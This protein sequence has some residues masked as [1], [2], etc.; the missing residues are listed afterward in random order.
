MT[1]R[2]QD[3]AGD[4]VEDNTRFIDT[5]DIGIGRDLVAS[6]EA[7]HIQQAVPGYLHSANDPRGVETPIG[8]AIAVVPADPIPGAG[9]IQPDVYNRFSR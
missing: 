8:G 4:H 7:D 2:G 5:S 9:S 6:F 3:R 1:T